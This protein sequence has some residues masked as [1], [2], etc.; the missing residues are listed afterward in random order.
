LTLKSSSQIRLQTKHGCGGCGNYRQ[1]RSDASIDDLSDAEF[2]KLQTE[3][4]DNLP[5]CPICTSEDVRHL[6]VDWRL[7]MLRQ[8]Q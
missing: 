2:I 7:V 4:S 8:M 1:E 5:I 6:L 3:Y